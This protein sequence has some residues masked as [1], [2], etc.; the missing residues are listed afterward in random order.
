VTIG[1]KVSEFLKSKEERGGHCNDIVTSITELGPGMQCRPEHGTVN[2]I[3]DQTFRRADTSEDAV[4]YRNVRMVHH[5][6]SQS[7]T[8]INQIY[9]R[10]I[11]P[12]ARVLDLMSSWDSHLD[13]I[14]ESA[15]VHGLGMN[16]EELA[17]NA[18]L[19]D[20]RLQDLNRETGL[21]YPDSSYDVALC[22]V[23]V[24][25]LIRPADIFA[26][27]A[28]VLKPGGHF[29][30]TF[31]DRWF[32]PKVIGLWTELH[33][34]ERMGLVLE[35][36]RQSGQFGELNTESFRGWPRPTDDK[37]YRERL[38]SDPVFAVWGQRLENTR[39]T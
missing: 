5:T 6:D 17:S 8:I 19:S 30:V 34:F 29:V 9:R 10:F 7:R 38:V 21:P 27:V 24:E 33:P 1:G 35:Y 3:H 16:A 13:G 25:Y 20:A 11:D 18:R 37:Y 2:F 26:E 36:F 23:S 28:R 4:F 39:S 22:T 12:G 15:T 14:P 31:S 32:P